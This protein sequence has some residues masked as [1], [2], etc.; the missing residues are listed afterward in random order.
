MTNAD[1]TEILVVVDRSGSM[2]NIRQD[3][4]GG[5]RSYIKE[6][7]AVGGNCALS[8]AQFDDQYEMVMLG[9]DIKD[10]QDYKLEPRGMTALLDAVGKSVTEFGERLAGMAEEDR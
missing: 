2:A 4:E 1:Y 6:Q 8:L 9:V 5:L 7:Q 10:V 3:M